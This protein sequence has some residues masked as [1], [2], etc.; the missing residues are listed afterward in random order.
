MTLK[1]IFA[2]ILQ[3]FL[4]GL[5]ILAPITITLWA[6]SSLFN[7]V[8]NIL[9]DLV[10]NLSPG[11][12]P[13]DAQGE[14]IKIPGAGSVLVLIIVVGV[15]YISTSFI[16]SRMVVLFDKLL[17]KTPGIKVIYS[18]VKDLVEAFAGNKRK[19]NRAVLVSTDGTDV[20]RVG[21]ITQQDVSEFDLKEHVAVYIPQSYAFAGH[22]Y[23]VKQE[24]IRLLTSMTAG[25]AMKFAISGG[26]TDIEEPHRKND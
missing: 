12:L 9:P 22:V 5:I 18:T 24:R 16:V 13:K 15:G 21:F 8:D 17:E 25:E 11:L 19:F 4:Q 1:K 10:E 26:V 23:F 6:V 2:K 20:W 7:F 14:P 3:Y